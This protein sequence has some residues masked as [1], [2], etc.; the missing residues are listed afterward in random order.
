MKHSHLLTIFA[1]AG[2]L[3]LTALEAGAHGNEHGEAKATIGGAKVSISFNSPSLK[4]RDL[5]AM[6]HPGDLWRLGADIPT[7]IES[8]ADLDFGGTRV[9]KGKH[10]LLA[11]LVQPGEWTLVV[12]SKD[13]MHYE[14]SAKLAEVPMEVQDAKDPV[15]AMSIQLTNKA[16]RGVIEISWGTQHLIASFTPAK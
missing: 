11:R 14:P 9:P 8:D 6:I 15:E 3:C 1:V 5:K 12:S 16:G 13:R 10:V 7:T 2:A 4:G